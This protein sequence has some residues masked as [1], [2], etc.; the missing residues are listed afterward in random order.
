M[1]IYSGKF[2]QQNSHLFGKELLTLLAIC[3][4]IIV[5]VWLSLWCWG[6]DVDLIVSVAKVSYFLCTKQLDITILHCNSPCLHISEDELTKVKV[7]DNNENTIVLVSE[8]TVSI[9]EM[10][11]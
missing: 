8:R 2:G 11:R 6:L 10:F 5:Y 4:C 7:I 1:I 9:L 3:S